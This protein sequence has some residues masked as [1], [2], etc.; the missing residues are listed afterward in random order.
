MTAFL[1]SVLAKKYNNPSSDIIN[2]LAGLDEVDVIF[3]EFV[4]ALDTSIKSGRSLDI[5]QKAIE[6]ALSLT[7]GAYQTTLLSYFT[8]RDLFPSLMKFIHDSDVTSRAFE[9]FTL[10]GLLANYNKFEFQNPYRLRLDD[11]V[12]EIT[13]QRIIRSVGS[14]CSRARTRYVDIQD[15]VPEGWSLSSALGMFG[16]GKMAPG[17]KPSTPTIDPEVAKEMFSKLWVVCCPFPLHY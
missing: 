9:P 10:L 17:A 5:R 1:T 4:A 13:I 14:T 2:V 8:H 12:N 11:F 6:V 7:S 3:T 15:D 16:L